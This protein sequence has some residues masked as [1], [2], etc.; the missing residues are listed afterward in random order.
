MRQVEASRHQVV[1]TGRQSRGRTLLDHFVRPH[2]GLVE[3]TI[4]AVLYVGYT[5]SRLLASNDLEAARARAY[6]ILHWE[7]T[8]GIDV[9]PW[10]DHFVANHEFLGVFS[11]YWYA[12][13]H[14]L[15][16][17]VVLFLLYRHGGGHYA[18]ARTALA[19]STMVGLVFYLLMPT[20]PPR[21]SGLPYVDVLAE[22]AGAGWWGSEASAPRGFGQYT[23]QLAAMPSL[24][25]GW[26]VWVAA[27]AFICGARPIW[28]ILGTS[29]A[30][31][32]CLVVVGTGNHWVSDVLAG[33][34]LVLVSVLVCRPLGLART[35]PDPDVDV[36]GSLDRPHHG[37]AGVR[38]A[39]LGVTAGMAA[40][41]PNRRT[42]R[43][44]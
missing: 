39:D 24:H 28:K 7:S 38:A 12:S 20:A 33:V 2:H 9:E 14:Y 37:S 42:T 5:L 4:L 22:H 16:T 10:W 32:T 29:Y 17:A 30:L 25:A 26:A 21:L 43:H 11:S 6:D 1:R 27:V 31:I 19:L 41:A 15:V 18:W 13:G 44:R 35:R 8:L 23:N 34:A 36:M 3:L 40:C